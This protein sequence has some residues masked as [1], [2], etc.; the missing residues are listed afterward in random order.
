MRLLF[1]SLM[2]VLLVFGI[3]NYLVY[4]KTGAVP[5]MDL[6]I[7][8]GNWFAEAQQKY[9]PDQLAAQAKKAVKNVTESQ[10]NQTPPARVYKWTDKNGQIHYGDKAGAD[11]A[12]Q[13][14]VEL[15]NV[16][17]PPEP[18]AVP[19]YGAKRPISEPEQ[20]AQTPLEKARAAAEAI[21]ARTREQENF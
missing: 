16:I 2:V 1:K 13:I 14:E 3:G 6:R 8:S 15:K 5:L 20:P 12:E 9:A 17:S 19:E 7:S 10:G 4:L 18:V 11:T 21:N